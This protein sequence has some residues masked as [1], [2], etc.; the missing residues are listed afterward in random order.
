[1]PANC[2]CGTPLVA[3]E[4][5][6]RPDGQV[7]CPNCFERDVAA[8]AFCGCHRVRNTMMGDVPL[9]PGAGQT[10][11]P[12]SARRWQTG[13]ACSECV[14]SQ[15]R[16]CF[17]CGE[18]TWRVMMNRLSHMG[19]TRYLCPA[20]WDGLGRCIDCGDRFI[21]RPD[22]AG[23][24]HNRCR[25]CRGFANQEVPTTYTRNPFQRRVG[26]ELEYVVPHNTRYD[27][28]DYGIVKGDGSVGPQNTQ[29]GRSAEFASAIASGDRLLD[30]ISDVSRRLRRAKAFINPSCGFHVHL[31][32][33]RS[34]AQQ[35]ETIISYWQAFESVIFSFVPY[36]RHT[37]QYCQPISAQN[38]N[39][40]NNRYSALNV[41]AYS[42]HH[43]FEVRMHSGTCDREKITNWIMFLLYF[44][45]LDD[46]PLTSEEFASIRRMHARRKLLEL[47]RRTNLPWKLRRYLVERARKFAH[48]NF[49]K[50]GSGD[51]ARERS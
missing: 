27:L 16:R 39:W 50:S 20:C 33:S 11:V 10:H 8:C 31:D 37:S 28:T 2:G 15:R 6:T 34:T 7:V 4:S 21:N 40:R 25:N 30:V 22:P 38:P 44:F 29:R 12:V 41:V 49:T 47:F 43:S 32:M 14:P 19:S 24:R 13:Y 45:A 35:R 23:M 36:N 51:D 1:M 46:H 18:N 48:Y 26:F 5:Y 9:R 42:R 3:T 17:N